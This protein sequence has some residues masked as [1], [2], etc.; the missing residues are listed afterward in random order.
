L[1]IIKICTNGHRDNNIRDAAFHDNS[2]VAVQNNDIF[3]SNGQDMVL[4]KKKG[5]RKKTRKE[6]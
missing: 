3:F 6:R 5:K 1:I 2:A 4:Q